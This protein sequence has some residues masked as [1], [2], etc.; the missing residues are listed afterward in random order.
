MTIELARPP[1][2][3]R[4][5]A[6]AGQH[7]EKLLGY[8]AAF[9]PGGSDLIWRAINVPRPAAV[10]LLP[11]M[12]APDAQPSAARLPAQPVS[13]LLQFKRPYR[14]TRRRGPAPPHPVPVPVYRVEV[15]VEQHAVLRRLE[16]QLAA[17]A[18]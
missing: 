6:P 14:M 16:S 3:R 11:S 4:Y 9:D 8:D 10:R 12:F 17:D 18:V 13:L 5:L 7:I 15:S 1:A 2:G